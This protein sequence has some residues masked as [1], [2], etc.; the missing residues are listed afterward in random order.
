MSVINGTITG[1]NLLKADGALKTYE[2]TCNFAAYTGSSD[3]ATVTAL[4]AAVLAHVRNGKT[5]TLKA[6]QCIGAGKDA[7]AQDVFFTGPSTWAAA[8]SSD[9][10]SGSDQLSDSAGSEL[11]STSGT[12]EGVKLAVTVLES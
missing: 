7:N 11:T 9:D 4:G 8:I 1:V 6:V 10:A 12:T 5:T 2:V 3:T